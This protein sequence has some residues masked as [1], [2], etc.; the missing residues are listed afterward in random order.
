MD[1]FGGNVDVGYT[2]VDVVLGVN[3]KEE[4]VD[5]D[6]TNNLYRSDHKRRPTMK[7]RLL[8]ANFAS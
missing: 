2:E 6:G 8:T 3:G 7:E 1:P 5:G 4:D